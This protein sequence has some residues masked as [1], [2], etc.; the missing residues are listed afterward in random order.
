MDLPDYEYLKR[1]FRDLYLRQPAT[2]HVFDWEAGFS[3]SRNVSSTSA[4]DDTRAAENTNR[5]SAGGD[6][7][8][9]GADGARASDDNNSSQNAQF[10]SSSQKA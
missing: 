5:D 1:L 4:A 6:R 10:E 8:T 3:S 7:Q 9:T 2:P